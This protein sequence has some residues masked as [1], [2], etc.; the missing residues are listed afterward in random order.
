MSQYP[1]W[2]QPPT[3]YIAPPPPPESLPQPFSKRHP[4]LH[5]LLMLV[6]IVLVFLALYGVAIVLKGG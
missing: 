1:N 3:Q 4:I 2:Q 6:L 5:T